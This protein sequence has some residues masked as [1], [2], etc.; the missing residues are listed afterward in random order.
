[1]LITIQNYITLPFEVVVG[2]CDGDVVGDSDVVGGGVMMV[3][4]E[5]VEPLA[6]KFISARCTQLEVEGGVNT[7][8]STGRVE[9]T[10]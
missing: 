5:Q 2:S 4:G 3:S 8:V 1:M 6:E 10:V 9:L 7:K